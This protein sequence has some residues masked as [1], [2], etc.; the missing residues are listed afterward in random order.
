IKFLTICVFVIW[1]KVDCFAQV[2]Y[3]SK[4][5]GNA[6]SVSTWGTNTDGSGPSPADFISGDIFIVRN[7]SSLTT[8]GSWNIDDGGITNGGVLRI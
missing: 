8:S 6:N 1:G 2:T 4:A 3:Y 7:G 5:S